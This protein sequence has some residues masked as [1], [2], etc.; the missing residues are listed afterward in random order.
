MRDNLQPMYGPDGK[1]LADSPYTGKSEL[2]GSPGVGKNPPGT[3]GN[4]N[5]NGYDTPH[6][7]GAGGV[8]DSKSEL[9]ASSSTAVRSPRSR[10]SEMQG[11]PTTGDAESEE[12]PA[13]LQGNDGPG[14]TYKAYRPPGLGLTQ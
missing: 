6:D 10:L 12:H 9:A 8:R 2:E 3:P 11:S 4:A 5:G 14:N 1:D 7:V 13:E